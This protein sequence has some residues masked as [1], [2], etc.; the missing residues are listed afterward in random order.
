MGQG[1]FIPLLLSW[2]MLIHDAKCNPHLLIYLFYRH[3]LE[4]A[5]F[6]AIPNKLHCARR[7]KESVLELKLRSRIMVGGVM[8][9]AVCHLLCKYLGEL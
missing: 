4:I 2:I 3:H 6:K 9:A 7:L 1:T 5:Y 8:N